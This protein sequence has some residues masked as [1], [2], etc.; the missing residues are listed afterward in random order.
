VG[1]GEAD[2]DARQRRIRRRLLEDGKFYVVQA[3]LRGKTW[4]RCTLINPRTT[5]G[6]LADLLTE[7]RK[8]VT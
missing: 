4:L 3:E 2:L 1:R 7:I 6:D 5:L 8:S